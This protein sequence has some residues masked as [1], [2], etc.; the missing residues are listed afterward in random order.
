MSAI[1]EV[2]LYSDAEK[3]FLPLP[4]GMFVEF[5]PDASPGAETIRDAAAKK[6]EAKEEGPAGQKL[7]FLSGP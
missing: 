6:R 2:P 4:T 7:P 5:P 1:S 3:M